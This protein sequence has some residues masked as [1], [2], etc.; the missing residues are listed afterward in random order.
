MDYFLFYR[1]FRLMD[2]DRD[3][4]LN[5]REIATAF[6]S[7]CKGDHVM[8]LRLFYCLHLPG[9][10][11]WVKIAIPWIRI[12]KYHSNFTSSRRS[13]SWGITSKTTSRWRWRNRWSCGRSMW[14]R[15]I[16][17][18]CTK[19]FGKNSRAIKIRR[20][21]NDDEKIRRCHKFEF[22]ARKTLYETHHSFN[23]WKKEQ[24]QF[25]TA[26]IAQRLFCSSLERSAWFN[27][28]W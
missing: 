25:K 11:I 10:Y 20:R 21:N 28:I 27:R 14:C 19:K 22:F 1:L 4:F 16:F 26:S 24:Q 6:N 2:A 5:F 12:I 18:F 23:W 9:K 17:R 13:S 15:A 3:G 7:M 8:K